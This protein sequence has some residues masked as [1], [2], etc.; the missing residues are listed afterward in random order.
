[1]KNKLKFFI[2]LVGIAF[3]LECPNLFAQGPTATKQQ[4]FKFGAAEYFATIADDVDRPSNW[5]SRVHLEQIHTNPNELFEL[6]QGRW[7]YITMCSGR[8]VTAFE[9]EGKSISDGYHY[10]MIVFEFSVVPWISDKL[11]GWYKQVLVPGVH[12]PWRTS[13]SLKNEDYF[14]IR[15]E[16]GKVILDASPVLT[17]E[18]VT[19]GKILETGE[20]IIMSTQAKQDGGFTCKAGE[21]PQA[22]FA[23]LPLS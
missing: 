19:L 4:Q 10:E 16:N 7:A 1:M 5:P 20:I 6:L 8:P 18:P 21:T 23:Q 3:L 2:T 11:V 12:T 14:R 13:P 17:A 9:T 15:E 22:I